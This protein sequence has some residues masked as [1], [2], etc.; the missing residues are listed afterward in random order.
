[1]KNSTPKPVI[2]YVLICSF[3]SPLEICSKEGPTTG[4]P[5]PKDCKTAAT[6]HNSRASILT[7]LFFNQTRYFR[8]KSLKPV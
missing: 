1:M 3:V 4:N 8:A 5:D 7:Q 2:F 6:A